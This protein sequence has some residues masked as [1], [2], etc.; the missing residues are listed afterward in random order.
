VFL[1]THLFNNTSYIYLHA[2]MVLSLTGDYF[3][4]VTDQIF[5]KV[6]EIHKQ[7]DNLLADM[8]PFEQLL[9]FLRNTLMAAI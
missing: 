4:R 2:L 7:V 6:K 9:V 5:K 3:N 1:T 8:T